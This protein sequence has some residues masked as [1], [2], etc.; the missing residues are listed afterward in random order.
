MATNRTGQVRPGNFAGARGTFGRGPLSM[1]GLAVDMLRELAR[2]ATRRLALGAMTDSSGGTPGADIL[3]ITVPPVF[4]SSAAGGL[5]PASLNT[6][7]D[8]IANAYATLVERANL[9]R[10]VLGMGSAP[11]GP[12]T[13]GGGTIGAIAVATTGGIGDA[14]AS[15]STVALVFASL[16]NAQAT[17]RRNVDEILAALGMTLTTAAS[18]Q[19]TIDGDLLTLPALADAAVVTAGTSA[20]TGVA[21]AA[22]DAQLVIFRNNV[23][24]LASKL[25]PATVTPT[26]TLASYAAI[27]A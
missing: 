17:A 12:G 23:A 5:T 8:T 4:D 20:T 18:E 10:A 25:S 11:T 22:V 6:I 7:A 27:G 16:L 19:G 3:T 24:Y 26:G 1:F 13:P 15:Q 21:K 14:S 9:V 2:T